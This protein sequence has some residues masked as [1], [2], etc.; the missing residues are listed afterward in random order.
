MGLIPMR[1]QRRLQTSWKC[2]RS[3]SCQQPSP[4]L[5]AEAD[6]DAESWAPVLAHNFRVADNRGVRDCS[7]RVPL[8]AL[9]ES[10]NRFHESE[11]A[12]FSCKGQAGVFFTNWKPYR[13]QGVPEDSLRTTRARP[14]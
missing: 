7:I 6:F 1:T 9:R 10:R 4:I 13:C 14:T 8:E 5:V 12:L 2:W 11:M 3:Y